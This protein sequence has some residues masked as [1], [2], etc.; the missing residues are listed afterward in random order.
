MDLLTVSKCTSGF[1]HPTMK[2]HRCS[3]LIS[4]YGKIC[5]PTITF[6]KSLA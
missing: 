2:A 1:V 3:T 6:N 5:V 4:N